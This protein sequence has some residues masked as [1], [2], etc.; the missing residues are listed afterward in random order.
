MATIRTF[1]FWYPASPD[2][3]LSCKVLQDFERDT[4]LNY[5][6]VAQ[7]NIVGGMKASRYI[8]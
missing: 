6:Y 7:Q 5:N 8:L 1:V 2:W 4:M 3:K